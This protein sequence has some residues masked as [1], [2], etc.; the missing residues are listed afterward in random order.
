MNA[1]VAP[2]PIAADRPDSPAAWRRLAV[3]VL[4]TTIGGVG[5]WSVVVVLPAVQAE[6]GIDRAAASLPYTLTMLGFAL[7]GVAMGRLADRFG[8]AAPLLLGSLTLAAGYGATALA[9]S[10]WPFAL[11]QGL[12]IGVGSSCAFAPLMADTSLWFARRRGIAVSICAAGNYLAGTVWPPLVQHAV[13]EVGWR[14]TQA[15]LGLACLVTMLPLAL[16][17]RRRPPSQA[18]T[19]AARG[20]PGAGHAV[21]I[22]P[23]LLQG[24]LAL[25][26]LSCCVAMAMPQVH[27]VAYCGDLGY[28][29]ARGAEMLSLMLACG[30]VSRLA[31]GL[32]AD[33]IGGVATLLLGAV[34]QGAALAL[35]LV[36][37]GLTSLYVVS[38]LFGLFQGGI[39]PAYAIIVRELFPPAEA[40]ARVGIV[41]M[42]TLVG[43]A[44]GGWLSGVIFDL[45]GTY[46]AAFAHGLLWNLVTVAIGLWLVQR[47][48][49]RGRLAPA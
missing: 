41:I 47:R 19:G 46:A 13:A 16:M 12:L 5:M 11:A 33:R 32:L 4:L 34:L 28:G 35:Y 23:G 18:G 31:S 43:M 42:A 30:I 37:D 26:G 8:I 48:A 25:S 44:L 24:L 49:A 29:V 1:P 9:G 2:A 38:A 15:G 14:A 21:G 22:R 20:G 3:A 36:F 7:G 39:V 10:L 17:M 27:I 6:F 40:G 45:T